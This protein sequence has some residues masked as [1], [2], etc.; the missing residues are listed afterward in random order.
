M[1]ITPLEQAVRAQL[2][3]YFD[4]LGESQARDML[5]MVMMCV[6]RP[7]LEVALER[8]GGNQSR[9][10]EMLGITRSTLRKKLIAHKLSN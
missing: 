9:A 8:T 1:T 2:E 3:R 6:E 5:S 4:D 10:A 7:V